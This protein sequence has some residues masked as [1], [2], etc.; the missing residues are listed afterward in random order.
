MP[1]GEQ[2]RRFYP[3]LIP[4]ED[5]LWREWLRVHEGEFDEFVYNLH[6]GE[7]IRPP[8]RPITGDE[9]FDRK[10]REAWLR[11]TQKK[12]DV[13]ARK[14]GELWIFEVEERPGPR[15]L[16]QLLMYE[17]LLPRTHNL[18]GPFTLALIARRIGADVL[19]AFEAQGI[20]VWQVTLEG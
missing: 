20:V 9:A 17:E 2:F 18:P 8:D 16:G 15:A 13:V 6:V 12:I 1:L 4:I 14:G 5:R 10:M 3:G 19:T 11:W 7:G